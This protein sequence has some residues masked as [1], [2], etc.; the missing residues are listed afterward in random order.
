MTTRLIAGTER[1]TRSLAHV[2]GVALLAMLLLLV[3]NIV[4]RMLDTPIRSTYELVSMLVLVVSAFAL[5]EAQTHKSHVAIDMVTGRLTKRVQLVVGTVVTLASIALFVQLALSLL[6]YGL[7]QYDTG[8]ATEAL[9][10][11]LWPLVFVLLVGV[12]GL[13]VA[14]L[15]DLGRITACWRD[16]SAE[17]DIW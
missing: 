10:V 1:F 17:V 7:N 12:V 16:R 13:V 14:L 2:G 6:R 4:L 3:A 11:P 15:G 5:G 8:S 9:Q